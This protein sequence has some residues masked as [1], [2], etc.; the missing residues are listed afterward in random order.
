MNNHETRKPTFLPLERL[1]QSLSPLANSSPDARSGSS[2][3]EIR[4]LLDIPAL[5]IDRSEQTPH[6]ATP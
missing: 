4:S 3:R 6:P 1:V 5:P 2:E